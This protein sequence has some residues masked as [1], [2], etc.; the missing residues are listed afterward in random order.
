MIHPQCI[1]AI[2]LRALV[3]IKSICNGVAELLSGLTNI[4][5]IGEVIQGLKT[6]GQT[7]ATEKLSRQIQL[8]QETMG[9]MNYQC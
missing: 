7:E 5:R 9:L 3:W 2:V 6:T 1:P 4:D 8:S